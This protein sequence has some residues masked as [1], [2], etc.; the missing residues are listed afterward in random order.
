MKIVIF[1]FKTGR[2]RAIFRVQFAKL[3][4]NFKSVISFKTTTN[5]S[6][7]ELVRSTMKDLAGMKYYHQWL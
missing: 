7:K 1:S 4:N 3:G 6:Q 2:D 5:F